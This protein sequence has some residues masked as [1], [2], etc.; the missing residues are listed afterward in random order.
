MFE[1]IYENINDIDHNN[2]AW[3][4]R[5][6][7]MKLEIIETEKPL[8]TSEALKETKKTKKKTKIIKKIEKEYEIINETEIKPKDEILIEEPIKKTRKS[9]NKT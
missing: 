7:Q 8:V 3:A 9:K 2:D 1:I 5:D 4:K 6:S